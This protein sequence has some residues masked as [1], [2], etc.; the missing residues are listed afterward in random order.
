[1]PEYV[2]NYPFSFSPIPSLA[3]TLNRDYRWSRNGINLGIFMWIYLL[4]FVNIL[5]S[6]NGGNDEKKDIFW[7]LW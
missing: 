4:V 6:S 2:C 7:I 3:F 1:M 5:S